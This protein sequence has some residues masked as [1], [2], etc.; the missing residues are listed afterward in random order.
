MTAAAPSR[1]ATALY[2]YGVVASET[3]EGVDAKGVAGAPVTLLEHGDLAA[4]VSSAPAEFRIKRADLRSHLEV[5][6]QAFAHT[7]VVPCAFGTIVAS[8][9]ALTASLLSGRREELHDAL[10]RLDR[11]V[12]LNVRAKYDEE[13]LLRE[14]VAEHPEIAEMQARVRDRPA[15]GEQLHLGELVAAA[16][17]D[18]RERDRARLLERLADLAVEFVTEEGDELT[19]LKGSFLVS[20]GDVSRFEGFLEALARDEHHRMTIELVGPL[21]PTAFAEA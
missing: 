9:D 2:V 7:T 21:P 11:S 20:R 12:Q 18:R 10:A 5:L 15:Y 17:S 4:I 1:D 13:A 19:A 8:P 3:L 16:V 6:E 14:V